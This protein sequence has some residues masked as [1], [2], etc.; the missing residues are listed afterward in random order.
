LNQLGVLSAAAFH[1]FLFNISGSLNFPKAEQVNGIANALLPCRKTRKIRIRQKNR[2]Q[3]NELHIF[4]RSIFLPL[5]VV[6]FGPFKR[7]RHSGSNGIQIH[8]HTTRQQ[9]SFIEQSL[10]FETPF[11]KRPCAL[12][13]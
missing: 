12:F 13:F 5:E 7:F 9:T 6:L 8:I 3:K 10:G 11:P 2:T 1:F 4:L